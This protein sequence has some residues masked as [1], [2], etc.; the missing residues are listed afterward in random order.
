M[1]DVSL[2]INTLDL[3]DQYEIDE[4]MHIQTAEL[5]TKLKGQVELGGRTSHV[6]KIHGLEVKLGRSM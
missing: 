5:P 2:I 3:Y 1:Y 6:N 4:E